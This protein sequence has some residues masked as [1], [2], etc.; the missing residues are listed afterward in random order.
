MSVE[1]EDAVC[2]RM[3]LPVIGAGAYLALPE[4]ARLENRSYLTWTSLDKAGIIAVTANRSAINMSEVESS[5]ERARVQLILDEMEKLSAVDKQYVKDMD[6]IYLSVQLGPAVVHAE[7]ITLLNQINTL[8][9][10]GVIAGPI[11]EPISFVNNW[12]LLLHCN[13][14]AT[15]DRV[16]GLIVIT[17]PGSHVYK[18]VT[19]HPCNLD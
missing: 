12:S 9:H 5:T 1:F 11:G 18:M 6:P 4:I 16:A 14:T 10:G 2:S 3:K 13:S 8:Q 15:Y 7:Y 17:F 19:T